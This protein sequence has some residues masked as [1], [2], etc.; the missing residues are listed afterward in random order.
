M[1]VAA[2]VVEG[3]IDAQL[4][5]SIFQGQPLVERG[6]GKRDI[7]HITKAMRK[8]NKQERIFY[9]R[10]RDFDFLPPEDLSVPSQD[11]IEDGKLL[12]YRWCRHEIENY[13]LEPSLVSAAMGWPVDEFREALQATAV[14]LADY[15]AARWTIGQ[16]RKELPPFYKL[17]THPKGASEMKLPKMVSLPWL[18]EWLQEEIGSH[19]ER[20]SRALNEQQVESKFQDFLNKFKQQVF[21]ENMGLVLVWFSGKDLFGGLSDWL[22]ARGSLT[23]ATFLNQLKSWFLQNSETAVELLPEWKA[24]ASLLRS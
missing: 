20:I 5:T 21:C 3:D 22:S 10:D 9:I 14:K 23:P 19:R 15:Q 18:T 8:A 4:L 11:R 24:L 1:P 17:D 7:A 13:L 12:G 6:H 16:V 2:L